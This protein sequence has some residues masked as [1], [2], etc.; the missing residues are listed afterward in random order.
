[1]ERRD[2]ESVGFQYLFL[3]KC[4]GREKGWVDMIYL[5]AFPGFA[6]VV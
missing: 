4:N 2:E 1:M 5:F 6:R 3:A